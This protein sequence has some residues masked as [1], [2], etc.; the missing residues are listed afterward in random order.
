MQWEDVSDMPGYLDTTVNRCTSESR[1]SYPGDSRTLLMGDGYRGSLMLDL[2]K[3][4]RNQDSEIEK[5]LIKDM[6]DFQC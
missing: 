2:I 5:P 4:R 3:L 6:H 1:V